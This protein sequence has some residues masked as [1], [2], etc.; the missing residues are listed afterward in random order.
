MK[1]AKEAP[2]NLSQAKPEPKQLNLKNLASGPPK[3][4]RLWGEVQ[5]GLKFSGCPT[6]ADSHFLD[7]SSIMR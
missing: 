6:S 1:N 7:G 3:T 5:A 2:C 4:H